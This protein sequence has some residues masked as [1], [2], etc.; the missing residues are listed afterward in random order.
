[1]GDP[2]M[3]QK[4]E[5]TPKAEIRLEGRRVIRGD[6]TNDWGLRL[7]WEVRRDGKVIATPLA[8]AETSYE[9]ADAAP[10]KYEIVLQMWKYVDYKKGADGEFTTSK[11]VDISNKVTY[12]I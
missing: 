1:M 4:F 11:Y 3:E 10:G 2:P 7:Q 12:T 9:H 6:V 8:R 5:G